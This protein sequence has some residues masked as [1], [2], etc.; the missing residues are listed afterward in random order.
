MIQLQDIE[1]L[2]ASAQEIASQ[3]D[4]HDRTLVFACAATHKAFLTASLGRRVLYIAQEDRVDE[5]AKTLEQLGCKTLVMTAPFDTLVYRRSANLSNVS[6]RLSCLAALAQG[7]YQ[8]VVA[9]PKALLQYVPDKTRLQNAIFTIAEG[10][11]LDPV[12]LADRLSAMGYARSE[13]AESKGT[14]AV[15]GEVV[16][17]FPLDS[18]MPVRL[19]LSFDCIESIKYYQPETMQGVGR[20]AALRILPATDMLYELPKGELLRRLDKARSPLQN[21]RAAS[22]TD[23]ILSDIALCAATRPLDPSLAWALP[24]VRD[25]FCDLL[26]YLPADAVVAIDEPKAI[27]DDLN[28]LQNTHRERVTRLL[29][30]GE[31]LPCHKDAILTVESLSRRLRAFRSIGFSNLMAGEINPDKGMFVLQSTNLPAYCKDLNLLVKD[32]ASYRDRGFAI[33]LYCGSQD[34][35]NAMRAML[36]DVQCQLLPERLDRGFVYTGGKCVVVGTHDMSLTTVPDLSPVPSAR[37]VA[38][39]PGDYVVHEEYGIGRCI[40][41][42]HVKT[43]VGEMDYLALQ[44]AG[45]SKI[46]VPMHQL[47]LLKLYAGGETT[48]KLSNPDKEEFKQ[49]KNKA[50]AGIRKLAFDLLELYAKREQSTGYRYPPDTPFQREFEAAFEFEETPDQTAAVADIKRDMESG[51]VMDRLICGDVG[52][53]KTEVALRA[54]FKTVMANKQAA[55][56]APTTILAEQ[57]FMTVSA[58]LQP[59]GIRV[60]CLSRFRST[61][62]SKAILRSLANGTV[63]VVVGT[64]RLLGKDV[65]FFDLGLLVLDEEQRFGVEHKEKIKTIRNNVNVLSL[66]ATPIPRTLHMALSG[67]RDVSVLDTPPKGRRDVETIVAEYTDGLLADAVTAEINRGG[68]V[69]VLYNNIDKIYAFYKKMQLLLPNVSIVVGHGKMAPTELEGNVYKFYNKEA[70][71]LLATTIIENGIDVPNANTLFVLESNHLGLAQM[72]QLKGRVGRSSRQATAYFTYPEGY[73]PTGDVAKRLEALCDNAGLGSGYRLALR[74]LEIRGAGDVLGREQHGHVERIGYDMYCRLLRETI[75]LLKGETIQTQTN[76][77]VA[78]N[79]DAYIPQTYVT[80]ERERLRLYQRIASL[81][82]PED[83]DAI[84]KDI[85]ELYGPVPREVNTLLAVSLLRVLGSSVGVQKVEIDNRFCRIRFANDDYL[86]SVAFLSAVKRIGEYGQAVRVNNAVELIPAKNTI[87]CKM[88]LAGRFLR[89]L[90]GIYR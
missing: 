26:S 13:H 4:R 52:F 75:A 57:H 17:I 34:W 87:P 58:R 15:L 5:T 40:G 14:F 29:A 63:G 59:F 21:T 38:P 30:G 37:V 43:S 84:Q 19:L 48:P 20:C 85:A 12:S 73:V 2:C 3:I 54:V 49:Q 16:E 83:M 88:Q 7:D 36:G 1:S 90:N 77:E 79:A 46:Y 60:A 72:Y 10:Q 39:K 47:N 11:A 25:N 82:T 55:I 74:D 18:E 23:E 76:T 80:F 44:Y 86:H 9:S 62:E 27:F 45:T 53:G 78:V 28:T 66:S 22:R 70:Q 6:M 50:R 69:F 51:R 31:V 89:Y 42:Q 71:V 61:T 67:I 8:A 65:E 32:L 33:R 24:V 68:Q 35:V 81:R 56:L 64:H 41:V